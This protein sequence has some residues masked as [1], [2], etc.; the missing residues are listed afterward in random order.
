MGGL[1]RQLPTLLWRGASY[2]Q[3]R[4]KLETGR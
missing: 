4:G 2:V 3:Y 1:E